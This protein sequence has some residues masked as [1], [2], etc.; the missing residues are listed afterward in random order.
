[1]SLAI[2]YTTLLNSYFI[3]TPLRLAHFFAQIEAESGLKP[4]SENLNYSAIGLGKTFKKYFSTHALANQYARKPE[5][6]ANRVYANRMGNG[7]EASGDGWK[8]RGR[9]FIQ[10]TGKNNFIKLSKDTRI[11]YLNNPDW[12]L[13]EGDSM[14]SALW[15][16]NTTKLNKYADLDNVDA[17]SD[18]INI[19]RKTKTIG[20]ANGF[21]HRADLLKKYKIEFGIK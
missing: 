20:D 17:I 11:D 3:N 4:I 12:L 18:L 5:A 8:F 16:W 2:K 6:I 1:M 7:D 15:Y 9:G 10:I 19:G 21:Q 13:R 14:I